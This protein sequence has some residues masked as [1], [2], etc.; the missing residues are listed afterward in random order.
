MYYSLIRTPLGQMEV[1]LLVISG[2][3]MYTNR[4]LGKAQCVL[5]IEVSSFQ[6]VLIRGV[7]PCTIISRS[8]MYICHVFTREL[9][10]W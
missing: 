8:Y 2:V 7:P 10:V 1:S 5:L 4:L 6:G 9:C 3:V